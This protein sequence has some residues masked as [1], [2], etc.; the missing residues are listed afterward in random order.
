VQLSEMLAAVRNNLNE[1]GITEMFSDSDIT[2]WLN[3]GTKLAARVL[4]PQLL[5]DLQKVVTGSNTYVGLPDDFF[6]PVQ[7]LL[8][9][10][11][12]PIIGPS[13]GGHDPGQDF[14]L[15]DT[16][17]LMWG[18]TIKFYPEEPAG[19]VFYYLATPRDMSI[20][21]GEPGS[22]ASTDVPG[23][24][25]AYHYALVCYATY[26]GASKDRMLR[27]QYLAM[28]RE[29]LGEANERA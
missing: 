12:V 15:F 29:I 13:D 24:P 17:G 28:F 27:T 1:V 22:G 23:I 6:L 20:W 14:A 18:Y 25:E 16:Y 11:R 19:Y 21:I 10:R 8:G 2:E 3:A 26:M 7:L 9:S 4:P 5:I